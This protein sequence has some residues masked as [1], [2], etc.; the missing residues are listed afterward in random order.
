[1][2]IIPRRPLNDDEP[3]GYLESDRDF[4]LNNIDAAVELLEPKLWLIEEWVPYEGMEQSSEM[5]TEQVL[6]E[7]KNCSAYRR[8]DIQIVP[9]PHFVYEPHEFEEKFRGKS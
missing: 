4:V 3:N 9:F 8:G 2:K 7:L 6:A 1:M 5:T